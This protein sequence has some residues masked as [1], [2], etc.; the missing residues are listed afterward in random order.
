MAEGGEK[1]ITLTL[2]GDFIGRVGGVI[3]IL[4]AFLAWIEIPLLGGGNLIDIIRLINALSEFGG[5]E[6][7]F[8]SLAFIVILLS[9]LGG[10]GVALFKPRIG[11]IMAIVGIIFFTVIT[12]AI[13]S[14]LGA[15]IFSLVGIGYYIA[16]IGSIVSLFSDRITRSLVG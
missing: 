11:G 4:S 13:Q 16:W 6:G 10:G 5:P 12:L 14:D 3:I 1:E 9:V 15:N 7:K 8:F 2:K